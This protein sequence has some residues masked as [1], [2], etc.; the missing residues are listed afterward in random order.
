[1]PGHDASSLPHAARLWPM[2][3]EP[4]ART[5]NPPRRCYG[6]LLPP[7]QPLASTVHALG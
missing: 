2:H 4:G 7:W 1:M 5:G 6:Y 3:R